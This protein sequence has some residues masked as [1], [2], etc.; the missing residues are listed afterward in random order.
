MLFK[1]TSCLKQLIRSSSFASLFKIEDPHVKNMMTYIKRKAV[2][3]V[4]SGNLFDLTACS[5]VEIYQH[6]GETY[7]FLLQG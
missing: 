5:L 1:S 4:K 6:F 7:C 2:Q 3:A